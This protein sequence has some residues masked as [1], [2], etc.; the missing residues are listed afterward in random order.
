LR[1]FSPILCP[2][3]R[4]TGT[5]AC[6]GIALTPL[7]HNKGPHSNSAMP[8]RDAGTDVCPIVIAAFDGFGGYEA[9]G[10]PVVTPGA[11]AYTGGRRYSQWCID[12]ALSVLGFICDCLCDRVLKS[13]FKVGDY[14]HPPRVQSPSSPPSVH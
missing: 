8:A 3:G 4:W 9:A 6:T 10:L 7:Y 14:L 2:L 12:K 5:P 13:L 1:F 11:Q